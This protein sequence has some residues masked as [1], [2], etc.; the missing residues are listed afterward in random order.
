MVYAVRM[1]ALLF[2][3]LS[4]D[5]H[6]PL[7]QDAQIGWVLV[8]QW[9]H[10][11]LSI[12]GV[13]SDPVL[14]MTATDDFLEESKLEATLPEWADQSDDHGVRFVLDVRA[15]RFFVEEFLVDGYW[16]GEVD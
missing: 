8:A 11:V 15:G 16:L 3:P 9:R 5:D 2:P 14:A 1:T 6:E 4:G 12:L 13:F 10:D 7:E